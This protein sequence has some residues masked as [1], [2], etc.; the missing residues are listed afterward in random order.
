MRTGKVLG[1]LPL[2]LLCADPASGGGADRPWTVVR[3]AEREWTVR[4]DAVYTAPRSV[5]IEGAAHRV[6]GPPYHPG[7]S[8]EG[9]PGLPVEVLSLGIPPGSTVTATLETAE[10]TVEE[11]CDVA[12]VPTLERREGSSPVHVYRKDPSAYGKLETIPAGV[13]QVDDPFE[14]RGQRIATVR[15][16]PF[17]YSPAARSLRTLRSARIVV[18][19]TGGE[20]GGGGKFSDP[21]FEPLFRSLL[22][23][24]EESRQ[25]RIPNMPLLKPAVDS[26]RAWFAAGV[27]Y[28]KI[29]VSRDG[30]YGIPRSALSPLLGQGVSLAGLGLVCRGMPVPVH[31]RGDSL[32][33]FYGYRQR[34][35]ST[36]VNDITDTNAYWLKPGLPAVFRE[37]TVSGPASDTVRASLE[38][39]HFEE[40]RAMYVGTTEQEVISNAPI[41]GRGWVWEFL[42]PGNTITRTFTLDTLDVAAPA[43]IAVRFF[44]TTLHY[45]TPD[46]RARLW[47]NDS[48][49]GE[50]AFEA[51]SEGVFRAQIP[52]G[53][54]R[55]GSNVLKI[56]SVPTASF[57]NQFYLDWFEVS[58]S[59]PLIASGGMLRFRTE[60]FGVGRRA[61]EASGFPSANVGVFDLTNGRKLDLASVGPDG[62]GGYRIL[63]TDTATSSRSYLL[64][65][66]GASR[67]PAGL[68]RRVFVDHR[69]NARGADYIV[70]THRLLAGAAAELAAHRERINAVRSAVVDVEDLYDEFN[71][72]VKSP[73]AIKE[74]L[75]FAAVSWPLPHPS[76]V[77][78]FGDACVDPKWYDSTT[79]KADLV[80]SYGHPTGDNWFA[81]FDAAR[82]FLP[83]LFLG[84]LPV[85]NPTQAAAVVAKA[86]IYDA[87]EPAAWNK[88]FLFI[89]GG[90]SDAEQAD[91]EQMNSRISA[92]YV[93]PA[94]VGG[95]EQRIGKKTSIVID[96]DSRQSIKE[97]VRQGL[98][99]MNFLGHSGG[100]IWN[101]DVGDP[102]DFE[103]TGGQLPFVTSVSCNVGNFASAFQ[104]CLAED[105]LFPDRR[106]AIAVWGSSSL[107][108][109]F[110]GSTLVEYLLQQVS[111]DTM[112]EL[113]ALTTAARVRLWQVYGTSPVSVAHVGLTP[114]LGDPLTR[115]AL[116]IRP[117]LSVRMDDVIPDRSAATAAD[118]ALRF[119]AAVHNYGLVPGD[120]VDVEATDSYGP[121]Q[122]EP[123]IRRRLAPVFRSDTVDFSLQTFARPGKHTLQ[124]S[125]DPGGKITEVRT[126]NNRVSLEAY[127]YSTSTK[128]VRPFND[129]VV[130]PGRVQLVVTVPGGGVHRTA[131]F[132]LDTLSSFDSPG[133]VASGA[134]VPEE[135]AARW[136]TPV[137]ATGKTWFWRARIDEAT[138]E[139]SWASS[140]FSTSTESVQ[141]PFRRWRQSSRGQFV[142]NLRTQTVPTDSGVTLA[143]PAPI[144]LYAR[145]LGA[146]STTNGDQFSALRI[147][148]ETT[149]GYWWATGDRHPDREGRP[150]D[151]A[152]RTPIVRHGVSGS[153]GQSG[154]VC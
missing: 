3:S 128:C 97:L 154:G 25:W 31:I 54:L 124:V 133:K 46:H 36:F 89:A 114:L 63:F 120:S 41:P 107:G 56:S 60:P 85:E 123:L 95:E 102:A 32:I 121:G 17:Q 50:I 119:R 104:N 76:A 44:S 2:L 141:A 134:V 147:N 58:R 91:F 14:L 61:F 38:T 140:A 55:A 81:C 122:P 150:A 5:R 59:R 132:E 72:G 9:V 37:E 27:P 129:E 6:F 131:F 33:E 137:L 66:S 52:A 1:A 16:A 80:P 136:A 118:T 53:V 77:L 10:Y 34:G 71:Y 40:N 65:P 74:F 101:V 144:R 96:G 84:R 78:F 15:L 23:N 103:N 62:R 70:I 87:Y 30:W 22:V 92:L 13:L 8:T 42:Y 145:S 99:H 86:K 11:G 75:R 57:P 64:A 47:V 19:A 143:S 130:P 100:R 21:A 94:P 113:G 51:R 135:L 112:R 152:V 26:T 20:S 43:S 39:E 115:L 126:A 48:L 7:S 68:H 90:N 151:G 153:G 139:G 106:G 146:R 45:S 109:A 49:A 127:V 93:L 125:L 98:V 83:S 4:Y 117:D 142:R 105:F 28:A 73:G 67:E 149:L 110:F 79:T 29:D 24:V 138:A 35:D 82:P 111:R 148:D 108:Y 12:P 116:P 88:R 69:S 18:R